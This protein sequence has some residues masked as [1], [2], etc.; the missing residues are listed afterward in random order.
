MGYRNRQDD[1]G[2]QGLPLGSGW[3]AA[4]GYSVDYRI[5]SGV[6][7]LRGRISRS[8]GSSTTISPLTGIRPAQTANK[9]A[10]VN[11]GGDIAVSLS[12]TAGL[13]IS[14]AYTTGDLV[15]LDSIAAYPL[16]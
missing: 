7:Y 1:T 16:G 11:P 4:G 14:S 12:A 6:V 3:S 2:W 5:I 13:V 9:L 10:R 15:D 8:S